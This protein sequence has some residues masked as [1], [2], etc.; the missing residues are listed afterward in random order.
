MEDAETGYGD[1][2]KSLKAGRKL[3]Y[4]YHLKKM[5]KIVRGTL[6]VA[7]K[8]SIPVLVGDEYQFITGSEYCKL[9]DLIVSQITL[10]NDRRAGEPCSL[11]I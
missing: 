11:T 8:T 2:V 9:W 3:S 5:A 1:S 10:F 6:L 4:Y 7:K